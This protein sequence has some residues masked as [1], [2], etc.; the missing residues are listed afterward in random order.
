MRDPPDPKPYEQVKVAAEVTAGA[1]YWYVTEDITDITVSRLSLAPSGCR[2]ESWLTVPKAVF[3]SRRQ[4]AKV[5]QAFASADARPESAPQFLRK[6][7][8]RA[9]SM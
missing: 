3:A 9:P 6:R 2:Y 8:F 5:R 4:T 7:L 1:S